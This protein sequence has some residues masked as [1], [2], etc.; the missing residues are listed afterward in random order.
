MIGMKR[1][2]AGLAVA[3][4]V[5][6]AVPQVATAAESGG[7]G[8]K[9]QLFSRWDVD[10]NEKLT[11]DEWRSSASFSEIDADGDGF[12]TLGEFGAMKGTLIKAPRVEI[13]E[14]VARG[15]SEG[16][17]WMQR[18]AARPPKM[19]DREGHGNDRQRST[20]ISPAALLQVWDDD[21]DGR[22]AAEEWHGRHPFT[23]LD[24]DGDGFLAGAEVEEA[25][26]VAKAVSAESLPRAT[27]EGSVAFGRMLA[28]LDTDRDGRVS[29][30]EWSGDEAEWGHLDRDGD[31][32]VT[33][34]EVK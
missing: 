8:V 15:S 25:A 33:A 17:Q 13:D 12:V 34:E 4:L 28:D 23:E 32:F 9:N 21:G 26:A 27:A 20:Q 10:K 1:T 24:H 11:P 18:L 3:A 30:R 29:R 19:S 7:R 6:A 2:L 14:A 16:D 22:L 31:G 5:T